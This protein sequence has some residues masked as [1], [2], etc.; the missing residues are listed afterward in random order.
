MGDVEA[1]CSAVVAA[2]PDTT[3]TPG[4]CVQHDTAFWLRADDKSD[5]WKNPKPYVWFKYAVQNYPQYVSDAA[6]RAA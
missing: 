1:C 6:L 4:A 5:Y 3:H 2:P